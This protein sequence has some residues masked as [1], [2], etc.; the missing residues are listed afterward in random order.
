MQAIKS[1]GAKDDFFSSKVLWKNGLR[2]KKIVVFSDV[3]FFYGKNR[4]TEKYKIK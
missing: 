1:K 4:E 3:Y 2:Y